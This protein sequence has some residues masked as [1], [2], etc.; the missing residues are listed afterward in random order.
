MDRL[1]L[2]SKWGRRNNF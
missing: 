1:E 2:P